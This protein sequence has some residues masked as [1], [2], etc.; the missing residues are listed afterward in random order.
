VVD[1][2]VNPLQTLC[3]RDVKNVIVRRSGT[4]RSDD[5][6]VFGLCARAFGKPV[7]T[8]TLQS[9]FDVMASRERK[10]V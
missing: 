7:Q 10:A 6:E 5:D 8:E 1:Y 3:R 2:F 9:L 4:V